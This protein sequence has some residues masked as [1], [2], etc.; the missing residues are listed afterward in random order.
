MTLLRFALVGFLIATVGRADIETNA[1][2]RQRAYPAI[3]PAII[4][5]AAAPQH[6]ASNVKAMPS[7]SN[8]AAI[9]VDDMLKTNLTVLG[10]KWPRGSAITYDAARHQILVVN[11]EENLAL[12]DKMLIGERDT[13]PGQIEI[14]L[15]IVQFDATNFL[16]Q[17]PGSVSARSLLRLWTNGCGRL[18]GAPR[19]VTRSGSEA[20]VRGVTEVI[21]PT[22]F[23]SQG[24]GGPCNSNAPAPEACAVVKPQD[25]QTR[26]V[27]TILTALPEVSP[28]GN[29][30]NL[31][32][33]PTFVEPPTWKDYGYDQPDGI[34]KLRHVPIEQ[35]FFQNFTVKT[36]VSVQDGATLLIGGG[37]PTRDGKGL[38]YSFLTVRL[39]GADGEPG[40]ERG[41]ASGAAGY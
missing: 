20:S 33:T 40:W 34:G 2:L 1:V 8:I 39:V 36:Q 5:Q 41:G 7:S 13:I 17:A 19:V 26:E 21:Y 18:L 23:E 37:T 29:M 38:I 12:L 30:I 25:F 9:T 14:D 24:G 3:E 35:P 31:T 32:L 22:T 6:K 4:E 27:G 15:L 16:H 11:T 28:D 10:V